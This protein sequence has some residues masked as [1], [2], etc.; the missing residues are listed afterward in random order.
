MEK[1]KNKIKELAELYDEV[2]VE[3][4][5][6]FV[7]DKVCICCEKAIIIPTLSL[8]ENPIDPLNQGKSSWTDGTVEMISCGYGSVHDLESYFIAICDS[9]ITDRLKKG[10]IENYKDIKRSIPDARIM[11]KINNSIPDIGNKKI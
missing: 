7:K 6:T 4:A 1:I 11:S 2:R 10:I 3:L 5:K 8:D 9:C